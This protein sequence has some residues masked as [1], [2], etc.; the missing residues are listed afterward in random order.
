MKYKIVMKNRFSGPTEEI[1]DEIYENKED[2]E[3]ALEEA[4]NN[5]MTGAEVLEMSGE[6]FEDPD[7]YEFWIEKI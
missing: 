5:F 2:A 4:I 3:C 1:D 7:D 6:C